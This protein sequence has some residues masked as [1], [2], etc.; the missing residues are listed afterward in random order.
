MNEEKTMNN[1]YVGYEYK[2]VTIKKK[3]ESIYRDGYEN[4]GWKVEGRS[5]SVTK[6]D[7]IILKLKRDRKIKNKAELSRLQQQ[8]ESNIKELDNLEQ[9][10][11]L[12][13]SAIAYFIGV[14]GCA[15][16][17]GS[18]FAITAV[19]P[20]IQ[21]C[22]IF[23]FIGAILWIIPYVC[24]KMIVRNKTEKATPLINDKYE[25]I[26]QVNQKASALL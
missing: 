16:M 11:T 26:Y 20:N 6:V 25:E 21:W 12:L 3:Y 10:K 13:G 9:S 14:L 22:I 23:G 19:I 7:S 18:V 5:I 8:F 15:F 17:A 2:E 1:D 24:Y 4:Y